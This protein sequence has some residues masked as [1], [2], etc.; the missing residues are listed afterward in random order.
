MADDAWAK[1]ASEFATLAELRAD[2]AQRM[3]Q[4]KK[5]Q[6][7]MALRDATLVP[8]WVPLSKVV[9]RSLT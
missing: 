8:V 5:M 4:V 7:Y 1:D 6:S 2:L 9:Q 3:G